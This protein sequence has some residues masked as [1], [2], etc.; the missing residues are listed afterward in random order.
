MP[1]VRATCSADIKEEAVL[2]QIFVACSTRFET[3]ENEF[4]QPRMS[5]VAFFVEF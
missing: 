3:G 2:Q 4:L 1:A 5:T